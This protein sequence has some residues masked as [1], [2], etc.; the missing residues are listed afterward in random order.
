VKDYRDAR[1]LFISVVVRGVGDLLPAVFTPLPVAPFLPFVY[2]LNTSTS[3][4]QGRVRASSVATLRSSVPWSAG[5]RP[6][7]PERPAPRRAPG[8]RRRGGV[9]RKAGGRRRRRRA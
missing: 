2:G 8:T 9:A 7:I 1:W 4:W 5:S 6:H 3:L